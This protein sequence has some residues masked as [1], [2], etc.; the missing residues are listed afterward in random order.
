MEISRSNFVSYGRGT[1][2]SAAVNASFKLAGKA[3]Q[4]NAG[5][6]WGLVRTL[7]VVFDIMASNDPKLNGAS[8]SQGLPFYGATQG[9]G[10]IVTTI[11]DDQPTQTVENGDDG[12]IAWTISPS[13]WSR[14]NVLFDA[15]LATFECRVSDL[16]DKPADDVS[17]LL[18]FWN[19]A[20]ATDPT[21]PSWAATAVGFFGSAAESQNAQID[22]YRVLG[23][24]SLAYLIARPTT[25][26]AK[27]GPV[28]ILRRAMAQAKLAGVTVEQATDLLDACW[29]DDDDQDDDDDDA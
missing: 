12:T 1:N 19:A 4:A 18:E 26:K 13:Q 8:F 17:N 21:L 6:G 5:S 29:T 14:N 10:Q 27:V 3:E 28:E 24:P 7:P 2:P 20:R 25:P 15:L 11:V 16:K 22:L 23:A 9:Y